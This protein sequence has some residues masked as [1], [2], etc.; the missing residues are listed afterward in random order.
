MIKYLICI[1]V[2]YLL[3]SLNIAIIISRLVFKSDVRNSGSGNA[4]ATNVARTFGWKAGVLTLAF[5]FAKCMFACWAGRSLLGNMGVCLAGL[6]C[7][8]GHCFP[9]YF[10]FKG[11]KGIAVGAAVAFSINPWILLI[12]AIVFFSIAIPTRY[13]SLSSVC[14]ALT[15]M[16]ASFFLSGGSIPLIVLACVSGVLAIYMHRANIQRLLSGTE[17]K[18]AFHK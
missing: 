12:L 8:F 5:D 7:M 14:C 3:G 13:V 6:G 9:V 17:K 16:I 11:G 18:F 2:G 15:L 10:H 4:G 1:L